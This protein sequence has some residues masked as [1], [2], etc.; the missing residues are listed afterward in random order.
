MSVL[1]TG[2]ATLNTGVQDLSCATQEELPVVDTD[3]GIPL[4]AAEMKAFQ[5]TGE[6]DKNLSAA[7][8]RDV[9][10]QFKHF[11][12][13]ARPTMERF[14]QRSQT[15]LAYARKIFRDKGLPEELAY[16]AIV[17]SGYN[18][19]AVSCAGASGAWQFMPYT[20]MKYGLHQDWWM[21]ER[22]DPYK[23]TEAAADYL[24]KL[25]GDFGNWHLAIA[26]Y[27]AGEGKISRALGST[28]AK[29]FTGLKASNHLLDEKAQLKEETQQYVPR[30]LAV[31]KIMRNLELLGFA[32]VNADAPP[33]VNRVEAAPGTDLTAV[34]AVSGLTWSEFQEYNGAHKRAVS[35]AERYTYI[36]VPSTAIAAAKG[37]RNGN[38][39]KHITVAK[40]D[41]WQSISQKTGVP[42][43]ALQAANRG[44]PLSSGASLR[45]PG[46]NG[47][48]LAPVIVAEA[49]K[50][51]AAGTGT[52]T[53]TGQ[54]SKPM[55]APA[56]APS[57]NASVP[58]LEQG[59]S[60]SLGGSRKS[61]GPA[62]AS[63]RSSAKS[64]TYTVQAGDTLWAIARKH[65]MSAD[66]LIALNNNDGKK[67]LRPGAVLVVSAQ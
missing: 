9:L 27:N 63:T 62:P 40:N 14:S 23:S 66:A 3:D 54:K 24:A 16:L 34:A 4:S 44:T 1:G 6:L 7:A 58:V 18:P 26:A 21:D 8:Q 31:S 32:P 48:R 25:Y 39:W 42:V 13:R 51:P 15:Y 50:V 35:H 60:G 19:K 17:E 29:D 28:G 20:G 10:Y 12:H 5:S 53:G 41:S 47:M 38:G 33:P 56:K 43:A 49:A 55:P 59:P 67:P 52:G 37:A 61:A 45:V 30:F 2:C 22:F 65:N 11:V 57:L 46:G 36:Y 64:A